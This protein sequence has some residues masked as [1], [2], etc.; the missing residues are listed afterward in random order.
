MLPCGS[1]E[2]KAEA[3]L[4]SDDGDPVA[5]LHVLQTFVDTP[6]EVLARIAMPTLVLIGIQDDR[7]GTALAAAIPNSQYAVVPGDHISAVTK[8]DLGLAIADYLDRV[9]PR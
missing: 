8:P 5:L 4:K 9:A 6:R 7:T 2:W 3:F 1:L